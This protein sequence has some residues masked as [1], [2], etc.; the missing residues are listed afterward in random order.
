MVVELKRRVE[1]HCGKGVPEKACLLELE[2]YIEEVIVTYVQCERY[3]EKGCPIEANKRQR[4]I[5]DRQRWCG[6]IRKVAQPREA[7]VQQSSM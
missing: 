6:Y 1:E 5:K 4:V 3:R 7:K 2:W